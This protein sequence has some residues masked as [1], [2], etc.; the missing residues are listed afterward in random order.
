MMSPAPHSVPDA[1]KPLHHLVILGHPS[2]Q[3]FD[4][5]LAKAYMDAVQGH[6]QQVTLRDLYA[7]GFNPLLSEDERVASD[8]TSLPADARHEL[9]LAQGS[10][11]VAFVYPIWFGAPPAVIMCY[12]DRVFGAAAKSIDFY[13]P[14]RSPFA[15]K[16]LVTISTSGA[17]RSWLEDRGIWDSL[18]NSFDHYLE[19]VAGFAGSEHYHADEISDGLNPTRAARILLEVSE[20]AD[21]ICLAKAPA[22]AGT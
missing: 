2:P 11:V 13:T 1:T 15:G 9:D 16:K 14:G 12:I 6:G 17:S 20:F 10:G 18:R 5:A 4:A 8:L 19:S 7:M 3:S 22:G 21:R